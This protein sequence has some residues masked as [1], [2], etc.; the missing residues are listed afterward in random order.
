MDAINLLPVKPMDAG[1]PRARA[2]AAPNQAAPGFS[3][4][5]LLDERNSPTPHHPPMEAGEQGTEAPADTPVRPAGENG[6]EVS[7]LV[8]MFSTLPPPL[9]VA[10]PDG[11]PASVFAENSLPG[12]EEV[13][14]PAPAGEAVVS[15]PVAAAAPSPNG[16]VSAP[17]PTP[18]RKEGA[19]V[20]HRV[21]RTIPPEATKL[22]RA[23]AVVEQTISEDAPAD[24]SE[25]IFPHQDPAAGPRE[26]V[27]IPQAEPSLNTTA[28]TPPPTLPLEPATVASTTSHPA[29]VGAPAIRRAPVRAEVLSSAVP[30]AGQSAVG[31]D[32]AAPVVGMSEVPFDGQIPEASLAPT[33]SAPLAGEN[34]TR[35][36]A[37]SH[38]AP[39]LSAPLEGESVTRGIPLNEQRPLP[40]LPDAVPWTAETVVADIPEGVEIEVIG[41]ERAPAPASAS[42]VTP[43]TERSTQAPTRPLHPDG[44]VVEPQNRQAT[45]P[46]RAGM[47]PAENPV[48]I[49]TDGTSAATQERVMPATLQPRVPEPKTPG[50][51]AN[52]NAAEPATPTIGAHPASDSPFQN[53]PEADTRQEEKPTFQQQPRQV[54]APAP[55]F[56]NPL[57]TPA[58]ATS[59]P[60]A[61]TR[62]DVET[63]VNRTVEAAERLR[64]TGQERVEVQVR[65]E[66]GQEL[67]VRLH[68]ANGEV[69]PVFLTD[70]QDLR[71]AIEQN[72]AQFSDRNSDRT[73]RVT[74]PVFE[75]PNSQ[76]G[77]NDLNQRQR[78][79]RERA[80]SQAQ[81]EAFA[82]ANTPGRGAPRRST[83]SGPTLTAPA[84]IQLYA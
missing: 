73:T 39:A 45:R 81:A 25:T 5:N 2:D 84:G 23:A 46:A 80:F 3:F 37:K 40:A 9:P 79:G 38:P 22:P 53:Q 29:P 42:A 41:S 61:I 51:A 74:T 77:M 32:R 68:L 26:V 69:K 21:P 6:A 70:S 34:F 16:Q 18:N 35:E 15:V 43:A 36:F 76:S 44:V 78:E 47:T 30:S 24:A 75:S 10:I 8:A 65:L 19:V 28:A 63:I 64:V 1:Q 55:T 27:A 60:T 58:P 20:E 14:P 33:R 67:T 13:R 71:R 50:P 52:L 54:T 31:R 62:T 48:T 66:A 49:S 56:G 72:W 59:E 7:T 57:T 4:E 12:T 82:A 11:L 17:P 83:V